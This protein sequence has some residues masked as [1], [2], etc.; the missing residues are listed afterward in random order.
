[1]KVV[2][3][4]EQVTRWRLF[5]FKE[6][7]RYRDLFWLL[8]LRDVSLRYKQTAIGVVWAI[9]Q[10]LLPAI[11]FA[12]LFGL[13]AKLP[14]DGAPYVVFVFC[15]MAVWNFFSQSL[16]RAGNSLVGNASLVTKIYFPRII[17]PLA[18]VGSVLFDLLISFAI[19]IVM[20]FFYHI[21]PTWRLFLFPVFVFESFAVSIGLSLWLSALNVKY[22]DFMYAMPFV[23]Q[24]WLYATPIVYSSSIVPQKFRGLFALNPAV[25]FVEGVRWSILGS[26]SLTTEMTVISLVSGIVLF[27]SGLWYFRRTEEYFA[28]VI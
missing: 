22:R 23:I 10:P 12:V 19:L 13:F 4:I 6:L 7:W 20:M 3:I 24:L 5:D 26:S 15:G 11:I 9:L 18:S 14:S 1:M 8:A 27:L 16:T 2:T 28:D 21:V 25:G 17:I